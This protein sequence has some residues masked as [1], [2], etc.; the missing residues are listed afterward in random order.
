MTREEIKDRYTMRDILERY[1]LWPNRAGF[2]R[3][4]FHDGDRQASLKVYDKD[5]NCFGC[6][7]NGDIFTFVQQ[8][9]RVSFRQA[10]QMLV[11]TYEKP[12]FSSRMDLYRAQKQREIAEKERRRIQEKKELNSQLIAVYRKWLGRLK[13]LSDGWCVC[14]NRLQYQLYLHDQAEW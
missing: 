7:A 6:G 9:E 8:M 10:Y 11:G 4:P 2:I 13:P 5:Y 3:C 12:T 1:G 14:Y